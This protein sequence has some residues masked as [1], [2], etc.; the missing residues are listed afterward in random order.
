MSKNKKIHNRLNK[1]FD[2]IKQTDKVDE[3]TGK[4]QTKPVSLVS[5]PE[6][7]RKS[8]H[9]G[10]LLPSQLGPYQKPT[11]FEAGTSDEKNLISIPFQAG[12]AWNTI[13]IEQDNSQ[14]WN[15]NEQNLVRQVADQLG[16]AL[17]NAR[18]FEETKK[19]AQ[20]M[21]AVAEIAT[22]I[23]T[24][25]DLQ[26]LLETAVHLTQQ[27]FGLYHAHIFLMD[28][29][30]KTLVLKACGWREDHQHKPT[31]DNI[32]KI[33]VD[34]PISIVA[35][36]AR[37]KMPVVLND[38]HADPTWLPNPMLPNIQSEI[39][40]AVI[41]GEK[42][43][44]VLNVH[45][46][47]LNHFTDADLAIITTLAAQMGSAIQNAL[48]FSET[49][50]YANEMTLLNT[51]VTEAASTLD[52]RKSLT[53]IITHMAKAL[54][55]SAAGVALVNSNGLLEVVAEW[56]EEEGISETWME[57]APIDPLFEN[58]LASGQPLVWTE[59]REMELPP[60]IKHMIHVSKTQTVTFI[61]LMAQD[62][63]FGFASLHI[64]ETGRELSA[65]EMRLAT[66]ILTQV[67]IVVQN[68][69]LFEQTQQA[70]GQAN[71]FRQLVNATTQGI[72]MSD[73]QAKLVYANE[74]LVKIFG[75]ENT[76]EVIGHELI[77]YYPDYLKGLVREKI[78]NEV[79]QKDEWT[80]E[81]EIA[82]KTGKEITTI[83][84][85]FLVK[86]DNGNSQFIANVVTDIT[87][88]KE[89]AKAL[90]EAEFK[91][92]SI[93]ENSTEGIF[94]TTIDGHYLSANPALAKIYG[95]DT[96]DE[97]I[98]SISDIEHQL[99]VD[100]HRREEFV[101]VMDKQDVVYQFESAIYRKDG[102]IIWISENAR[103]VRG[104]QGQLLYYEGAVKDITELKKVEEALRR[105]N[106]YLATAAEVSRLISSTLDLP[107]LF[108]RTVSL[109]QSRFKYY[110]VAVFTIEETGFNATLREA[111]GEAGNEMKRNHH[112]LPVGSK[113]I[114]GYVT[115]NG[116]TLVANNTKIDQVHRANP[117]LPD[118]LAEAG[119][120]LK[121]GTRVI[122][123]LDIQSTEINS[124]HAED[125]AVLQSLSDQIAVAIDNARSYE[126]AQKAVTEI[127][128][129]DRIKSQF[130]ANMSHEL[131]TPLNSIIGFSRVI[132]KGIDGPVS[133]QQQQD[134]NAI[135]NSGQHLLGLINDILDL[136]KIEAGK[137]DLSVEE[138]NINDTVTSVMSTASGLVKDKN[139]KLKQEIPPDLPSIRADPMRIRQILLNLI[140][141]AAKFTD[142]GSITVS[143]KPQMSP[144]GSMEIMVSITDTGPGI[145][146]EDQSKLFLAFSQVDS[147][148]TRRTGGTG[149]GLSICQR[150][151]SMHNGR[152]GVQSTVGEGSTF[153]FTIPQYHQPA[154]EAIPG[155]GKVILCID[156]DQQVIGLYD[157]YLRPQG[158]QV[159]PVTNPAAARDSIKRIKPYAVTLDIMMP[160]IDGWSL[161]EELKADPET[162]QTPIIICSI[163]EE[164]E[165]G[166]SLGASDY[167]VKPI[168]EEDLLGALNRLNGDGTIKEVLIIDDSPDDLRLMEK[169]ISEH[170]NFRPILA[171]GGV[172]GWDAIVTQRP[173]AIILD[174]FMPDLNGFTILERLRTTP[175][176][177]DIP[178]IVV[179]GADLTP[180]EKKQLDN[181]GKHLLQKGM[182][183]EQELFETLTKV[184]KR[185]DTQ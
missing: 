50:R 5:L 77:E 180:D 96:P 157:R 79:M 176:L 122:G 138:M 54:S 40:V 80:G 13:Q 139:V 121:I 37:T 94:Q 92:R 112:F 8:I 132:L 181:L 118:T 66:A 9:T 159:V 129:L 7:P 91:Y 75:E 86:D 178:V 85:L 97:L 169:V 145:S 89:A 42:V 87:G 153:Y 141:N 26:T 144:T 135:Y 147:S 100:P 99:Y 56:H 116:E 133:D 88:Q 48:L 119:I 16:L 124:F 59:V 184:L 52:L 33:N 72:G 108:E 64:S 2:D 60:N 167:L 150:L 115:A 168:L 156:D 47:E 105:Q 165:K 74:A 173:E 27:R 182:L 44:G 31:L 140:S 149:L 95:Y 24:V 170:S 17:N 11:T 69:Q 22:R 6:R 148:P 161:L 164:E 104:N 58:M 30:N 125:I 57:P 166:F 10:S 20:L 3:D 90:Q 41:S 113:S 65:D 179:S 126:L 137:M 127:R 151:V 152:I 131:R 142:E 78:L 35:R 110:H 21:A 136:S 43:L 107:T 38:V 98:Q 73:M 172:R 71:T 18:L 158:Y 175:E 177:R 171:E 49:Q 183:D 109:I 134:L 76:K 15:D 4:G 93:F 103:A 83:N 123:A 160:E 162:R 101:R 68:A 29:D 117:L 185:L 62:R 19:S 81:L 32:Q 120:P 61:P 34:T 154:I 51:V 23:S 82:S 46:D 67:S 53:G 25:L 130:L 174:L 63:A 28:E 1:L 14:R 155:E 70:L 111:T 128:E 163:V 45:S 146:P 12:D 36:S 114:I 39:A 55:L 106:E 84:N 143:A 102:N